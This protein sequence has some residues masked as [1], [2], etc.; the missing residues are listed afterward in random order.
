MT[1][2][3]KK[4]PFS[5]CV[6]SMFAILVGCNPNNN[7]PTPPIVTKELPKR[8]KYISIGG[9]IFDQMDYNPIDTSLILYQYKENT[10]LIFEYDNNDELTSYG[11]EDGAWHYQIFK[12]SVDSIVI[13]KISNTSS[14]TTQTGYFHTVKFD[15]KNRV[16]RYVY[17]TNGTKYGGGEYEFDSIGNISKF[18][19]IKFQPTISYEEYFPTYDTLLNPFYFEKNNYV[20]GVFL[21][22]LFGFCRFTANSKHFPLELSGPNGRVFQ[23]SIDYDAANKRISKIIFKWRNDPSTT[24]EFTY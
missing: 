12:Q 16:Q 15:S 14:D 9:V 10:P 13:Y 18:T 22:D 8:P 1:L 5:I 7:T 11:Y 23:N 20:S 24:I 4:I 6:I 17:Y 2:K 21:A 19:L 3:I